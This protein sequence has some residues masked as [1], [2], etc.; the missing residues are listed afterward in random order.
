MTLFKKMVLIAFVSTC[1]SPA[2][3]SREIETIVVRTADIDLTKSDGQK[4]LDRRIDRAARAFCD[5]ANDRF[6][7][8]IRRMKAE[9]RSQLRT[10]L[11]AQAKIKFPA[12]TARAD[13]VI[14]G[15]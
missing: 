2:V 14:T 7:H 13:S 10:K 8:K 5:T 9:C 3:K 15:K 11:H 12:S 1:Y 6:G 4:T